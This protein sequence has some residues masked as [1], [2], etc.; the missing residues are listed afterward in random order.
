MPK[1]ALTAMQK[2]FLREYPKDL[3]ATQAAIRAGYSKKTANVM[4]TRLVKLLKTRLEE[5]AAEKA[6]A[7]GVPGHNSVSAGVSN[8]TPATH[9]ELERFETELRRLCFTD[10]R[11][12]F[13]NH[14]NPIDIPNLGDDEAAVLA[15]F[16]QLEEFDGKGDSRKCVG[17]TKKYRLADKI[18]ALSLYAKIKGWTRE[19][20]APPSPMAQATTV[21]LVSLLNKLEAALPTAKVINARRA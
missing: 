9:A 13:D 10:A 2:K 19:Q 5:Q 6:V 15:G 7:V 1:T 8:L 20:E 3:N 18:A 12:F 4:G 14:G 21:A 17:Y 16:E 11:K